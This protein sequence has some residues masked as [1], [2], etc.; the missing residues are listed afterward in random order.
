MRTQ[1]NSKSEKSIWIL[2]AIVLALVA[3]GVIT[4]WSRTTSRLPIN[5]FQAC[6]DAGG[7]IAESY[8]EQCFIDGTSFVND[9][10]ALKPA[11]DYVGLSEQAALDKAMAENRLARVVQRD[12]ESLAITMDLAHGRL[13][14]YIRNGTV[15]KVYI[16][17]INQ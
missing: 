2:V 11:D 17:D 12:D 16:E 7:M 6:K 4:V 13:N 15:E 10:Q 3:A 5:S 8:P 14:F 9:K 1:S